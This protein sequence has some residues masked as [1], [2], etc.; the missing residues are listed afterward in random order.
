MSLAYAVSKEKG[1]D[2]FSYAVICPDKN[3]KLSNFGKVFDDFRKLL[4]KTQKF[5]VI[6]L[7]DIRTTFEK[8][9][10]EFP[11]VVWNKEFINRYCF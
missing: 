8:I 4:I 3:K 2:E 5:K 11:N 6:Y 7:S 9:Q 1:F 10:H